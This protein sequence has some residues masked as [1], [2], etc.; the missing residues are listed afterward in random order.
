[1]RACSAGKLSQKRVEAERR[2]DLHLGEVGQVM[3]PVPISTGSRG[4]DRSCST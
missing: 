1:M 2:P 4:T 3:S